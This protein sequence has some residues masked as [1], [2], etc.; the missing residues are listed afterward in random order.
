MKYLYL[1]AGV[2]CGL[3]LATGLFV[4]AQTSDLI[5]EPVVEKSEPIKATFERNFI[6]RKSI[7]VAA[8]YKQFYLDTQA[9]YE[10]CLRQK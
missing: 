5:A 3:L 8:D 4:H 10:K 9:A 2:L 7:F 6:V 1:L